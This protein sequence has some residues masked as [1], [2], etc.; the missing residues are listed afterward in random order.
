MKGNTVKNLG[1]EIRTPA[2]FVKLNDVIQ[3]VPSMALS[4]VFTCALTTFAPELMP[5]WMQL[6]STPSK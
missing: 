3:L 2:V 6:A 4:T 1:I 5:L